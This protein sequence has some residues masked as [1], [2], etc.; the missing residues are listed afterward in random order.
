MPIDFTPEF[1]FEEE[2]PEKGLSAAPNEEDVGQGIADA[3]INFAGQAVGMP[4]SG[5]TMAAQAPFLGLDEAV[6]RH[7]ERMSDTFNIKPQSKTGERYVENLGN[8]L[9]EDVRQPLIRA[10]K[11]IVNAM[12]FIGNKMDENTNELLS[13]VGADTFLNFLPVDGLTRMAKATKDVVKK[14]SVSPKVEALD[15][16]DAIKPAPDKTWM[17]QQLEQGAQRD[18]REQSFADKNNIQGELDLRPRDMPLDENGMPVDELHSLEHQDAGRGPQV[19]LFDEEVRANAE[20]QRARQLE[21]AQ[22]REANKQPSL[23]RDVSGEIES[24]YRQ[25]QQ[26]LLDEQLQAKQEAHN[27]YLSQIEQELRDTAYS[28]KGDGQG[29]KTRAFKAPKGQR[30]SLDIQ[31]IG[32][33]LEK[34]KQR[35]QKFSVDV[36]PMKFGD[37]HSV[38]VRLKTPDGKLSGFVDFAIRKDGTLVAEN[39]QVSEA[40]RG[41]GAAARMYLAAREAG[42]DIAPGRVQTDLGNK[43]VDSLQRKGIINKEAEGKRFNAGD[44]NLVPLAGEQ[45]PGAKYT[46]KSQRGVINVKEIGDSVKKAIEAITPKAFRNTSAQVPKVAGE[47]VSKVPGLGKE[48]KDYIPPDPKADDIISE[49]LKQSDSGLGAVGRGVQSG[50]TLTATKTG[51]AVIRGVG[52]LFQN[53]TKR[54]ELVQRQFV[55]PVERQFAKLAR[56]DI[57]ELGEVLKREMF[58][59]KRYTPD[60]LQQA[61]FTEKQLDAYQTFREMQ[62]KAYEAQNAALAAMGRKPLTKREAYL[63]SRWSGPWRVPVYEGNKLVWYIAEKSKV[64]AEKALQYLKENGV[65]VNDKLSQVRY[66]SKGGKEGLEDAYE[67]LLSVLDKND[68]RVATL[69]SIA[70]DMMASDAHMSLNQAKH[71]EEKGNIRGFVGDRPWKD[72]IKDSLE[73][74]K[75]QFAYTKSALSWSELQKATKES[76]Q[77]LSNPELMEKQPNNLEYARQY[78][79]NQLG[80][81]ENEYIAGLERQLTEMTSRWAPADRKSF[82]EALGGVKSFFLATKLGFNTGFALANAIQPLWTGAWH[83]DLTAH[84]FK[85]N[86]A[87]SLAKGTMDA[88]AGFLNHL[89]NKDL[90][91]TPI[92]KEALNYAEANGIVSRSIYDEAQGLGKNRVLEKVGQ[93][94][95]TTV[96]GVEH[97][98]RLNAFM[99]FVHHLEQSG[100]FKDNTK[101]FEKAEEL[102]NSAMVDYRRGER[103]MMFE[104]MGLVG[105]ALSTLQTFKF[106]YYNQLH[107]FSQQAAKGNWKPLAAFM[108][109]Q[110]AIGGTLSMP[111]LQEIDDAWQTVKGW[112]PDSVHEPVKDF[113]IKEKMIETMPDWLS[114][115]GMSKITG[116]NMSNRFDSGNLADFSFDGLFPFVTDL[117]KQGSS[118]AGF[119]TNPNKTTFAQM[120]HQVAPPGP[121]QGMVETGMDPFKGGTTPKGTVYVNPN[122]L[123]DHDADFVRTPQQETYR[124]FGLRELEESKYRDQ[125]YRQIQDEKEINKRRDTNATRFYDAIVRKDVDEAKG[126]AKRYLMYGGNP[127]TLNSLI[128]QEAIKQRVPK[129]ILDRVRANTLG[130]V[131]AMKRMKNATD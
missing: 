39:A 19:D 97:W 115:G 25:R 42:Y 8:F 110:A 83:A 66:Q 38:M 122:H 29:P 121:I 90:P 84:G 40:L 64:R 28:P 36:E 105:N 72:P 56:K 63:S 69:Q 41:K 13:T 95:S 113:N 119:A 88:S 52:R 43:M 54:A 49:A 96:G 76:K 108:G 31:A 94:A 6:K 129:E 45:L 37:N 9:E 21:E 99:G 117:Y 50:A 30:G 47:V 103:P 98:A 26:Q 107:Y 68:P 127:D 23:E 35:F 109:I 101:L 32:E 22:A 89:F 57:F 5:L 131:Q 2:A 126:Y 120:A 10:A 74:F 46:P 79:K 12:P 100:V 125:R 75:E 48:L 61:G 65:D 93:V 70:E 58:D 118:V 55:Q 82:Y 16:L 53:A 3:A 67:T 51:S 102:T 81:G 128:E 15:K 33:G 85:H 24:A 86:P 34:I 14:P 59:G 92:G 77:I 73:M 80:F 78:A 60:Q 130:T 87:T 116:A 71:F 11:P 27:D 44:L 123:Q 18:L 17:E 124:K 62:D 104:K 112:L 91:M 111:F 106:N 114:Y 1:D 20:Q 4:L 7:N